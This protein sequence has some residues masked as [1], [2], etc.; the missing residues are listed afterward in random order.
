MIE[1]SKQTILNLLS[2]QSFVV[3]AFQRN[4]E[5]GGAEVGE[6]WDDLLSYDKTDNSV[7]FLGTV[8]IHRAES[9]LRI[10]DGQQRLTTIFLLLIACRIRARATGEERGLEASI[11][12]QRLIEDRPIFGDS[13]GCRIKTSISIRDVFEYI[14]RQ[15]YDGGQIPENI[16]GRPVKRQINRI[17]PVFDFFLKKVEN[18]NLDDLTKIIEA[19]LKTVVLRIDINNELEAFKIFER[20]N[21]RGVNLEA[22]DLLK[23]YLFSSLGSSI[24]DDWQT[25][26]ENT[27]NAFSRMLKYFYVSRQGPILKSQ[28]YRKLKSLNDNKVDLLRDILRFSEFYKVIRESDAASFQSYLN[29][30]KIPSL[31]NNQDRLLQ[32][33]SHLEGLRVFKITQIYPLVYAVLC[34]YQ[35]TAQSD[36]GAILVKFLS[37]L[38]NYHFI[39][40]A[41]CERLGNEV[42]GIYANFSREFAHTDNFVDTLEKLYVELRL[43]LASQESFEAKFIEISY[44]S[45]SV[46]INYIFDR[47]SNHG[48]QGGQRLQI[49]RPNT[50]FKQRAFNIEHWFPQNSRSNNE[51]VLSDDA[52]N[53]IGNLLCISS[54][55]NRRLSNLSPAAKADL[56]RESLETDIQNHVF[57]RRFL[58]KYASSGDN[59]SEMHILQRSKDLAREAY[60]EIWRFPA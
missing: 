27:D 6:F 34:A 21:A 32:A 42:E 58:H 57:V 26:I 41:V 51:S 4:Y 23:N 36:N 59:W 53:S 46:L 13:R 44:K 5:W 16:D 40:N 12:L 54:K 11:N 50:T 7:L 20:T 37:L 52:I 18:L 14:G 29:N 55:T 3:P 47:F 33:H 39:N 49:F 8:I 38:E 10:I 60:T 22:T 43:R 28:L 25:I 17:S 56:L 45:H 1:P 24:E 35:R 30:I 19:L 2:E 31:A 15:N 48:T 9:E